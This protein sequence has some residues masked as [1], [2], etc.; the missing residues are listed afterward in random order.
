VTGPDV[1]VWAAG[2]GKRAA[3]KITLFLR[4]MEVKETDEERMEALLEKIKV[5][6]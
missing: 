1:L 2:H 3:V 5:Y 4:G 6:N